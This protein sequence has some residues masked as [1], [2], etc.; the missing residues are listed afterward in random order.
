MLFFRIKASPSVIM[1]VSSLS[2]GF[3]EMH[4]PIAA[5]VGVILA[6]CTAVST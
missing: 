3:V 1:D 6:V 5:V 4:I 2:S